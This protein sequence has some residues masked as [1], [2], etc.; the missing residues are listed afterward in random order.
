[1]LVVSC[2]AVSSAHNARVGVRAVITFAELM[3][4]TIMSLVE[5]DAD[6]DCVRK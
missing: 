2:V 4:V 1:M 3:V 6:A 5:V